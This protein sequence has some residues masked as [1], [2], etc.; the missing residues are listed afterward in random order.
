LLS[1][2]TKLFKVIFLIMVRFDNDTTHKWRIG[3]FKLTI[4]TKLIYRVSPYR[5]NNNFFFCNDSNFDYYLIGI[6]LTAY[7][8]YFF[9]RFHY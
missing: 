3:Y 9:S 6:F 7:F 8:L 1:V 2:N 5:I 4:T